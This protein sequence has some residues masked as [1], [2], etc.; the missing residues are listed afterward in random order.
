M[1]KVKTDDR[2]MLSVRIPADLRKRFK[3]VCSFLGIK[4]QDVLAELIERY[5]ATQSKFLQKW[6]KEYGDDRR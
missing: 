2:V 4:H 1:P 6:A 5:T 3:A